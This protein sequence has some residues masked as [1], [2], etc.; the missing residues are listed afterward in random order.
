MDGTAYSRD[1]KATPYPIFLRLEGR[2]CLVV[3][4]GS[5]AARK[6]ESL[7]A[8]G[9]AVMVV[10]PRVSRGIMD[11][12]RRCAGQLTIRE[13]S[14]ECT[15]LDGVFLVIAA[16]SDPE[17]NRKVYQ[18]GEARRILVNVVDSPSLCTFF[19]PSIVRRGDLQIA[20]STNGK[21]P[22]LA[23]WIRQRLE[24]L[25]PAA[26]G[27]YVEWLGGA[28]TA[29][30][31]HDDLGTRERAASLRALINDESMGLLLAGQEEEFRRWM[32]RWRITEKL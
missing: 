24:S 27:R 10:A 28:R 1:R 30:R 22:L 23:K 21:S 13:Q 17:L 6:I 3:G 9:A 29:L 11:L 31:A 19:V 26:W 5:V 25:F 15:D 8:A 2:R 20:V 16:T 18:E 4:G 12:A 14:F 7:M 32:E